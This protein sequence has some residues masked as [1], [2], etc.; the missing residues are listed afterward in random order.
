MLLD[1]ALITGKVIGTLESLNVRYFITGS[2]ASTI[3]GMVRT[4]QASDIVAELR[5]EIHHHYKAPI[6]SSRFDP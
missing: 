3:H 2:L 6:R 4:T 5:Q 1:P